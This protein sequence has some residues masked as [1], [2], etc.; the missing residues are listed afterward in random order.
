VAGQV[1]ARDGFAEVASAAGLGI[2]A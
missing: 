2:D 1:A